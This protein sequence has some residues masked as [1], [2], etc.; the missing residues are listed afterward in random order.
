MTIAE[1]NQ[2]LTD[3]LTAANTLATEAAAQVEQLK[4]EITERDEKIIALEKT[5]TELAEDHVE[6]L[7]AAREEVEQLAAAKAL[8]IAAQQGTEPAD[9]NDDPQPVAKT[10]AQLWDEYNSLQD[11]AAKTNFYRENIRGKF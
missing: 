3:D 7:K 10:E 9:E 11:P 1:E 2:K 6:Q 8:E 4:A 5:N